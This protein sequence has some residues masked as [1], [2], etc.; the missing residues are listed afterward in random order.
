MKHDEENGPSVG[1]CSM[2]KWIPT[3]WT[4][5][6]WKEVQGQWDGMECP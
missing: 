5:T 1:T 4:W 3:G 2:V 6:E